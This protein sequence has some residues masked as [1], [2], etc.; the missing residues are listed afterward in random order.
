MRHKNTL[1][2]ID[3]LTIALL[4][5]SPRMSVILDPTGRLG[6]LGRMVGSAREEFEDSEGGIF[7][8]RNV[9]ESSVAGSRGLSWIK[10]H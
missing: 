2:C 6:G 10:D 4:A 3:G 9:S 7:C 1:G 5:V 8:Y